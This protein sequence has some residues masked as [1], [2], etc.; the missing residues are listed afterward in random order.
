MLPNIVESRVIFLSRNLKNLIKKPAVISTLAF[1]VL[2]AVVAVIAFSNPSNT[3]E[4]VSAPVLENNTRTGYG[5]YI[6]GELIAATAVEAVIEDT[7]ASVL[8]ARTAEFSDSTVTSATFTNMITTVYGEYDEDAFVTSADL[9]VLLGIESDSSYT[10]AVTTYAG[11]SSGIT[12]NLRVT[13]EDTAATV[14]ESDVVYV[15]NGNLLAT[16][17]DVVVT[18]GQDGITEDTYESVYVNGQCISKKFLSSTVVV[19]AVDRV[20]ERG[21]L[22]NERVFASAEDTAVDG[23]PFIM[24]YDG[25]FISSYYGWR[26][27]GWHTGIDIIGGFG[28]SCYGDPFWAARDGVVTFADYSGTYGLIVIVQHEDG[29]ETRYAHCSA[30]KVEVGEYVEQGQV[31]GNIGDTGYVTGAHLHFEIRFDGKTVNPL[32]YVRLYK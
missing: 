32:E 23:S 29:S 17:E 7:L 20:I 18:E 30:V 24:P 15:D 28:V 3:A 19:E 9:A 8:G 2:F 31:I 12:L 22:D 5:L 1:F 21:V 11:R 6:D 4:D 27:M 14:L 16:H 10:T 25:G 13:V 26:S